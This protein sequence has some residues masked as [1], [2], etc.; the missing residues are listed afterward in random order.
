VPQ[1]VPHPANIAP[2]LARHE[3]LGASTQAMSRIADPLDAA[4]DGIP[5]PFVLFELLTVHAGEMACDPLSVLNL[6]ARCCTNAESAYRPRL[7][8]C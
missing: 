8:H 3:F 4:F 1:S 2:G 6:G 5:G 7:G